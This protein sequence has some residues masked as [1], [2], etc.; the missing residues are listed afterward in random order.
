[1]TLWRAGSADHRQAGRWSE[2][3]AA[4][5]LGWRP[6]RFRVHALPTYSRRSAIR[7]EATPA[8][9]HSTE[10]NHHAT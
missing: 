10:V 5:S 8:G 3:S 2:R 9:P 4:G 7:E 1:M 6:S